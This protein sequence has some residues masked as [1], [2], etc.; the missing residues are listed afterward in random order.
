M[1]CCIPIPNKNNKM[2][3]NSVSIPITQPNC[4]YSLN[5]S[6]FLPFDNSP[7][8]EFM[9]NLMRRIVHYESFL[10][11]DDNRNSE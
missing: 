11:K 3:T 4:Q 9:A 7:P 1:S 10:I 8:N 5:Q 6:S 2:R